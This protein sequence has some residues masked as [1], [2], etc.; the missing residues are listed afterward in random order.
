MRLQDQIVKQTQ[1]AMDD[2]IR[3]VDAIPADK[4]DWAPEGAR[5]ALSQLR[6]IAMV[7]Q[8]YI[9]ILQ[10]GA[11]PAFDDHAREK[12]SLG[13]I[14]ECRAEAMRA[15]SELCRMIREFPDADLEKEVT[16]PFNG[17]MVV[18]M[19]DLLGLHYWNTVYHLGQINFIQTLLGDKEMH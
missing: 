16:L 6:E 14:E 12:P 9:T 3:S 13:T 2:V 19:A 17:G 15:T 5:S 18:T 10:T 7:P 11:P 1:R 4:Q 8:F